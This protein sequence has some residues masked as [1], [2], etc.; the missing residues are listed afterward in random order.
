ML[1]LLQ[2][3]ARPYMVVQPLNRENILYNFIQLNQ[4]DDSFDHFYV[5]L[6]HIFY[7]PPYTYIHIILIVNI[8]WLCVTIYILFIRPIKIHVSV[9]SITIFFFFFGLII[10]MIYTISSAGYKNT[11]IYLKN[12]IKL[13]NIY[14]ILY[15]I[16]VFF[17]EFFRK[18]LSR[19][20]FFS[21]LAIDL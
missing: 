12:S 18:N 10:S 20:F 11:Y 6:P 5:V 8:F 17:F 7:I 19:L 1:I 16:F 4:L 3:R 9:E 21:I 13:I 14:I 15:L 2:L